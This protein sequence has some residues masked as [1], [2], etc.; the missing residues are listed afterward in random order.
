MR[1]ADPPAGATGLTAAGARSRCAAGHVGAAIRKR[2]IRANASRRVPSVSQAE[3]A[4][5]NLPFGD[6]VVGI[7]RGEQRQRQGRV[8][9]FERDRD[10][11]RRLGCGIEPDGNAAIGGDGQV[12][13]H[14]HAGERTAQHHPFAIQIDN[15]QAFVRRVIGGRKTRGQ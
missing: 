7:G 5:P 12:H 6:N 10:K 8:I 3:H 9:M 2:P 4:A 14:P 1:G 11:R 15:A 13:G